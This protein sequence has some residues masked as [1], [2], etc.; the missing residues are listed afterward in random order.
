MASGLRSEIF[1]YPKAFFCHIQI[2]ETVIVAQ[3][4][5]DIPP[6]GGDR[7]LS[8]EVFRER[9]ADAFG[10][11][12]SDLV[13]KPLRAPA[14]APLPGQTRPADWV[15]AQK[16]A[17]EPLP[18]SVWTLP[19]S[20]RRVL[21]DP[22]PT[23]RVLIPSPE[24]RAKLA[25]ADLAS[26]KAWHEAM[27]TYVIPLIGPAF[28]VPLRYTTQVV[29]PTDSTV[30]DLLAAIHN[31]D[32]SVDEFGEE[33]V[34][35]LFVDEK[36]LVRLVPDPKLS[37]TKAGVWNSFYDRESGRP[38]SIVIVTIPASAAEEAGLRKIPWTGHRVTSTWEVGAWES[39]P[40]RV[41]AVDMV[42]L[43]TDALGITAAAFASATRRDALGADTSGEAADKF[44][45]K[46]RDVSYERYPVPVPSKMML[47]FK[48]PLPAT[49]GAQVT[50]ADPNIWDFGR[51][52]VRSFN[53]NP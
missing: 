27:A 41:A 38:D 51:I 17:A 50:G 2:G 1:Y 13:F 16:I 24:A 18:Y 6:E 19:P 45:A 21:R 39:G 26:P 36:H 49:L 46:L 22:G 33:L 23:T 7:G 34:P 40:V 42:G 29:M 44:K 43:G 5:G 30:A 47:S 14:A 11:R 31:A 3:I 9:A 12:P 28:D 53:H 25:R 37:L 52:K 35:C 20:V 48:S 32:P 4:S 8:L 15:V 10:V